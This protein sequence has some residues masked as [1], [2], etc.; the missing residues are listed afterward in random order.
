MWKLLYILINFNVS[1]TLNRSPEFKYNY[2]IDYLLH[3]RFQV[4]SEKWIAI[5]DVI[6]K[7]Y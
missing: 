4:S 7:D 2:I 1:E 3:Y 5:G 6:Y